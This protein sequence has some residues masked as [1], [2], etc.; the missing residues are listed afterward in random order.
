[1]I[2]GAIGGLMLFVLVAR[3]GFELAANRDSLE[4][5]NWLGLDSIISGYALRVDMQSHL[6][7]GMVNPNFGRPSTLLDVGRRLQFGLRYGF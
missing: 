1:M 6:P 2:W 4:N 3:A 7:N 5:G